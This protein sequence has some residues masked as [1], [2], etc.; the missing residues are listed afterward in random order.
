MVNTQPPVIVE[1]NTYTPEEIVNRIRGNLEDVL[2]KIPTGD[3]GALENTPTNQLSQS[4][5][6]RRVIEQG[7]ISFD[8][9]LHT[10]TV[11]GTSRPHIVTLFL[12][13]TCSCPTTARCDHI[14]ATQ[15]S[16]GQNI[17]T[18]VKTLNLT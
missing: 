8:P 1:P 18:K 10:F 9:K 2:P 7:K 13:E 5:R 15:L 12:K 17:D 6:A 16:I 4:E 11:M 3:N 14:L